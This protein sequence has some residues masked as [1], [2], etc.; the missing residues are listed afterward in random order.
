MKASPWC[1]PLRVGLVTG[2]SAE[3][4]V[5]APLGMT[6]PGGGTPEGAAA[7][8]ALLALR[9]ATALVSFGLC[10][11]LDPAL[12]PG[13]LVVPRRVDRWMCDAALTA[14]LGGATADLL[15]A[16]SAIAATVAQ[17]AALFAATGAAAIDLESG[18]VAEVVA[19]HGL[20]FAVLR[21]VCDPASLAL[22]PAAL[23]ALD[24]GGSIRPWGIAAS[25]LRRPGQIPALIGLGR[26]ASAARAALV[27]RVA[28]IMLGGGSGGVL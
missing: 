20:P 23:L 28:Q 8:A 13:A 18:A 6:M 5:A 19:R 17:K 7:V 4:L 24:A 2:L 27:G 3:A 26:A 1:A 22:P 15:H 14:A 10:G 16:G 9:G 21:A 25:V 11:G 12:A